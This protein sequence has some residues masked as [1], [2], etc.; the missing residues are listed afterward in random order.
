MVDR[1][2]R[3]AV[4]RLGEGQTG[5]G[6]LERGRRALARGGDP[7]GA[8]RRDE[9][10]NDQR[11]RTGRRDPPPAGKPPGGPLREVGRRATVG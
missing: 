1:R 3:L 8:A 10:N 11:G 5:L 9:A 7:D 2:T 4:V 6:L